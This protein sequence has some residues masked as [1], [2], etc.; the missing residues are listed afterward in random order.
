M[1]F[2]TKENELYNLDDTSD[3]NVHKIL[4]KSTYLHSVVIFRDNKQISSNI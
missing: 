2:I 1:Y 3:L 4:V